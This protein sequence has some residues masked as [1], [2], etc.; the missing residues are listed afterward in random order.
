M[1]IQGNF[2]YPI[3]VHG[4]PFTG[5]WVRPQT[6]KTWWGVKGQLTLIGAVQSREITI[7][8][9]MTNW[10]SRDLLE[11]AQ[12]QML[13]ALDYPLTGTLYV[14]GIPYVRCNFLGW[15]NSGPAFYDGSGRHGWTQMGR[16]VW[17]QTR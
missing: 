6:K 16:L 9:T 11:A 2:Q 10:A 1:I 15:E 14:D 3:A 13:F 8:A 7:E 12:D 5:R 17:E 4:A